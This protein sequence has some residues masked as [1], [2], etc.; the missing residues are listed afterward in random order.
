M[1]IGGTKTLL[2]A[3]SGGETVREVKW[4]TLKNVPDLRIRLQQEVS[5]LEREYQIT[6][7]AVGIAGRVVPEDG[8]VID[9]PALEWRMLDLK[10]ELF[11]G[12]HFPCRIEN[13]TNIG[14][15]AEMRDGGAQGCTDAVYVTI[16]TGVGCSILSGGRLLTG[17][18]RSAGEIGYCV[19]ENPDE[20]INCG[21]GE[22]GFLESRISGTALQHRAEKI[23]LDAVTL[24][25]Q[26]ENAEADAIIDRFLHRVSVMIVNLI[27]LLD[28][29][30]VI[31]GGGVARSLGRYLEKIEQ[32][33]QR[34][35]PMRARIVL[36]HFDN[37]AGAI[38]ACYLAET[39]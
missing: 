2:I 4:Q 5:A 10:K 29:E 31:L 3:R 21:E 17:A 8:I 13:D 15:L 36:S 18:N 26:T 1:D 33:A 7:L 14:L 27:N 35:T 16:G 38:G 11:D 12:W 34:M 22:F 24:F 37:R 39:L 32:C 20:E 28:P 19:F 9:A 23:G 30:V 25:E 6:G